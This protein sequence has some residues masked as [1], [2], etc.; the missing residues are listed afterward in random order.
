VLHDKCGGNINKLEILLTH[1]GVRR[2]MPTCVACR[3]T[4]SVSQVYCPNCGKINV[5]PPTPKYE[6]IRKGPTHAP[7][8]ALQQTSR[9]TKALGQK[10]T[11]GVTTSISLLIIGIFTLL[12]SLQSVWLDLD[13]KIGLVEEP[14]EY[15]EIS[16][17]DELGKRTSILYDSTSETEEKAIQDNDD[18]SEEFPDAVEVKENTRFLIIGSIVFASVGI[19]L[20]V[21]SL[22][23]LPQLSGIGSFC[24]LFF[25]TLAMISMIY[26]Y[27]FFD[28]FADESLATDNDDIYDSCDDETTSGWFLDYEMSTVCEFEGQSVQIEMNVIYSFGFILPLVSVVMGVFSFLMLSNLF[29][30]NS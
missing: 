17:T 4:Y 29:S 1:I 25:T 5:P 18:L 24:V 6:V 10:S 12:L 3:T 13:A 11:R 27:F 19:L 9:V 22:V 28:P 7:L 26:F 23:G 15:A 8:V 2:N 16:T 20:G 14:T 21:L 30:S